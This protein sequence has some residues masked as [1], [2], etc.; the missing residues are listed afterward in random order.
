MAKKSV[1][2]MSVKEA[3]DRAWWP[4]LIFFFVV[5]VAVG[6]FLIWRYSI[7]LAQ[8]KSVKNFVFFSDNGPVTPVFQTDKTLT[9]GPD[10]CDYTVAVGTLSKTTHCTMNQ[11]N[12]NKIVDSYVNNKIEAAMNTNNNRPMILIGGPQKKL[13]VNQTNGSSI[14]T[15]VTQAFKT[16]AQPFFDTVAAYAP[17]INEMNF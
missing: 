6:G 2:N 3:N 12:F 17:Q 15:V 8:Y 7:R 16:D 10:Q 9:I 4:L 13:T 5:I 1:K 11:Q 14:V